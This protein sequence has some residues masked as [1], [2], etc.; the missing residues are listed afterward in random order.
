MES[1]KFPRVSLKLNDTNCSFMVDGGAS[2]NLVDNKTY[3]LQFL[4]LKCP[5]KPA[6]TLFAYG[7]KKPISLLGKF[8]AKVESSEGKSVV[9]DFYV[10]KYASGCLLSFNTASQLNILQIL[11]SVSYNRELR[12]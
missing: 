12:A 9:A 6:E 10:A 4:G 7:G 8:Q 11:N 5:L 3:A 2:V 1:N